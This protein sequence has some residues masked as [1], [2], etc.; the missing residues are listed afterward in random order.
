MDELIL[1]YEDMVASIIHKLN[2][3]SSEVSYDELMQ[4]G[5]LSIWQNASKHDPEKGKMSTYL[6]I[7]IKRALWRYLSDSGKHKHLSLDAM[8]DPEDSGSVADIVEQNMMLEKLYSKFGS[9]TIYFVERYINGLTSVE[10]AEAYNVTTRKVLYQ[11]NKIYNY[12]KED[13]F[14]EEN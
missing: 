14:E 1:Q 4:V 6:Y 3:V 8:G 9:D 7:C 11:S 5:R 2:Y 10:I 13:Y 12:I